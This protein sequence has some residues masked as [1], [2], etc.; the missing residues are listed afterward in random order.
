MKTE[1]THRVIYSIFRV[2]I[3]TGATAL[4]VACSSHAP[5]TAPEKKM[6]PPANTLLPDAALLQC[7]NE[8]V[9]LK[10]VSPQQWAVQQAEFSKL[11]NAAS[12][13]ASIRS[14]AGGDTRAAIDSLYQY[15]MIRFCANTSKALMN[16][17]AEQGDSH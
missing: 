8:L 5:V 1:D 4:A 2:L 14:S 7:K 3:V 9:A 17:L 12:R 16:G 15:R 6:K 10:Q 13:Y 11:I